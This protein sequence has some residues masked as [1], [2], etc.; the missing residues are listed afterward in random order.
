MRRMSATRPSRAGVLGKE[1]LDWAAEVPSA[2]A[3]FSGV[4]GVEAV[5]VSDAA[6]ACTAGGAATVLLEDEA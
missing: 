2:G 5:V 4:A 1:L 6:T 3:F